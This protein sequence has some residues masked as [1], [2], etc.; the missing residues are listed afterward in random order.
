MINERKNIKELYSIP[1]FL[2][3]KLELYTYSLFFITFISLY[4]TTYIE[5]I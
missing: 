1:G 3:N 2:A 5:Y 4:I